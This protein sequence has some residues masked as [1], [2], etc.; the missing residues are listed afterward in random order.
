MAGT[1]WAV[2]IDLRDLNRRP[3]FSVVVDEK[4]PPA[5]VR[6]PSPGE[7]GADAGPDEVYLNWEKAFNDEGYLRHCP[8]CGCRELFVRKDFPQVTGL[9]LIVLVAIVAMVLFGVGQVMWALT[10]LGVVAAVDALIYLFTGKCLVCYRC[11][12]EFRGMRIRPGHPGWE[13]ATGE[14]YRQ[15][16]TASTNADASTPDPAKVGEPPQ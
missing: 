7:A 8:A 6:R 13:L 16:A 1:I 12:S 2:R 4:N 10:V 5:V 14:K 9:A 11:R 15:I 3:L